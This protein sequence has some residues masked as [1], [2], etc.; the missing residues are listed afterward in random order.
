MTD[1]V[2][3]EGCW[4]ENA[5]GVVSSWLYSAG[6]QV[7][8]GQIIGELMNG[9]AAIELIAPASGRLTNLAPI[10]QPVRIGQVVARIQP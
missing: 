1:V 4:D 7:T 10:E 3:P 9:K 5:E 6:D 2:I 8:Q